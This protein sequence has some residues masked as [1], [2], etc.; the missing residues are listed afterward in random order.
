MSKSRFFYPLAALL[1]KSVK[2][3]K[4][5]CSTSFINCSCCIVERFVERDGD[6]ESELVWRLNKSNICFI[7]DCR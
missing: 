7:N 6:D 2:P 5:T 1:K 4:G 3:S